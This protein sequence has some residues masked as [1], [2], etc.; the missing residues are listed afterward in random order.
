MFIGPLNQIKSICFQSGSFSWPEISLSLKPS[1]QNQFLFTLTKF[2]TFWLNFNFLLLKPV[3]NRISWSCHH[4][5]FVCQSGLKHDRSLVVVD[6]QPVYRFFTVTDNFKF[7]RQVVRT[8]PEEAFG[9]TDENATTTNDR[10]DHRSL[11]FFL[12]CRSGYIRTGRFVVHFS[13]ALDQLSALTLNAPQ[14]HPFLPIRLASCNQH[15]GPVCIRNG[16]SPS[17]NLLDLFILFGPLPACA[18]R[19]TRSPSSSSFL[20][21]PFDNRL[22]RPDGLWSFVVHQPQPSHRSSNSFCAKLPVV[23][24]CSKM[25]SPVWSLLFVWIAMI[26]VAQCVGHSQIP[27]E[28]DENNLLESNEHSKPSSLSS[29]KVIE[30]KQTRSASLLNTLIADPTVP[31]F[32]MMGLA[33]IASILTAVSSFKLIDQWLVVNHFITNLN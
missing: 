6:K 33:S 3:S 14:V 21:T 8:S 16:R 20:S 29:G 10:P 13:Q 17:N 23:S 31:V 4:W 9:R 26:A 22:H 1:K 25:R 30:R 19:L 15:H 28:P 2:N 12:S 27:F 5:F 7:K 18:L 32:L 24:S 11:L